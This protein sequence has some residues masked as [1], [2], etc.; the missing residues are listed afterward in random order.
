MVNVD[1]D[2]APLLIPFELLLRIYLESLYVHGF[3]VVNLKIV[4]LPLLTF[5]IIIAI[6]NFRFCIV[7]GFAA[8]NLKI[9]FLPLL[10]FEIIIAI[11]NFRCS[12]LSFYD[13]TLSSHQL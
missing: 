8:V 9:V 6:G 11:G 3:A 2:W 7:H 10:T 5:E 4:I 1:V 13:F 12:Y